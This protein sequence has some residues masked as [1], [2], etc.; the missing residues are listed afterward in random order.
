MRK[1]LAHLPWVDRDHIEIS[2]QKQ[3]R[4]T[5]KDMKQFNEQRLIAALKTEFDG[6]RVLKIG[7]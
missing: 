2:T 6:A 3:V 4:L 5:V 7:K 1:A